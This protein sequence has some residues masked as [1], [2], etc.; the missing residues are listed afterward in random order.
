MRPLTVLPT[1]FVNKEGDVSDFYIVQSG[2]PRR[3]LTTR[4][5]PRAPPPC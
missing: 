5:R 4:R 3:P 1:D 2:A